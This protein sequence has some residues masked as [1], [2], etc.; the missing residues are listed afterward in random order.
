MVERRHGV[1]IDEHARVGVGH[2]GVVAPGVPQ[3]PGGVD[4][5][6]GAPVAVVALEEPAAAE[7]LAGERVG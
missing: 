1:G 2:D 3:Q 5:L 4:E 7:V 6:V